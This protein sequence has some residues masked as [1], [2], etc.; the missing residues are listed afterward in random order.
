MREIRVAPKEEILLGG[1]IR[2]NSR[3]ERAWRFRR[4]PILEQE[5]Y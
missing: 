2:D 3:H 1:K 4:L 5:V